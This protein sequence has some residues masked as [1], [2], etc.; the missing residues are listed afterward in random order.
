MTCYEMT[1]KRKGTGIDSLVEYQY[2]SKDAITITAEE[3][4]ALSARP[5]MLTCDRL[6]PYGITA[7]FDALSDSPNVILAS[8]D[9]VFKKVPLFAYKYSSSGQNDDVFYY[10]NAD[11]PLYV[12]MGK[13][14]FN[15][16]R[17]LC[18]LSAGGT[19]LLSRKSK[20][21]SFSLRQ[22]KDGKFYG[23]VTL[24]P[25][26]VRYFEMQKASKELNEKKPQA[27]YFKSNRSL[28]VKNHTSSQIVSWQIMCPFPFTLRHQQWVIESEYFKSE[29]STKDRYLAVLRYPSVPEALIPAGDSV[30]MTLSGV[31]SSFDPSRCS[32]FNDYEKANE[33][34][35][36]F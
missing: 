28:M 30:E 27:E 32:V 15:S 14:R 33:V 8:G 31:D 7:L 19:E 34:K 2:R 11:T 12:A 22:A 4:R 16:L 29:Y 6:K 21:F 17:A 1:F 5:S 35:V 10:P 3:Y 23:E 25:G 9:G 36:N 24:A 26:D 20:S 13:S 18:A